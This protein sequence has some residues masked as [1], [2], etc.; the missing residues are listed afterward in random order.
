MSDWKVNWN[1]PTQIRSGVGRV[2]ELGTL[3]LELGMTS[4]L[5]VTDSGLAKLPM[6]HTAL[7]QLEQAGLRASLFSQ[8]QPNPTGHDVTRGVTAFVEGSHDGIIALGGGSGLDAGKAIA[9]A[10]RQ[11]ADLWDFEDVGD[12]YKKAD[13]KLIPPIIAI[14]T[15]AGTGSEVGRCAVILD[16]TA[17]LKKILF[18]PNMLPQIVILDPELTVGLPASV[19]AATGMDALSHCL[20]ALC[21]PF[22][23]PQADG[24]ACEG[25]RLIKEYLPVAYKDGSNIEARQMMLVAAMMGATAF[26][27]GLGAMHALA[28]PLGA[29]YGTHHGLLNAI[30]MPYVLKAN[31]SAISDRTQRL[32]RYLN[33]SDSEQDPVLDWVLRMRQTLAIPH[34]LKEV[35]ISDEK[36]ALIASLAINDPSA[37]TNPIQFSKEEYEAILVEAIEGEL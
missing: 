5:L 10:A 25:I 21:S 15:T 32:A 3:C 36:T 20:E 11:S 7:A 18:H 6:T 13:P 8:V 19:T 24:I 22:F 28:H 26:Q 4:P 16:E 27:K 23:H 34:R 33:L 17:Q 37:S 2:Q 29:H 14:P 35:Q 9:L 30:L 12:N 1:Y 31:R